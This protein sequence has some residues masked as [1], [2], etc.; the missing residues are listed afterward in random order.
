MSVIVNFLK[1]VGWKD[2]WLA[3]MST[4]EVLCLAV[5]AGMDNGNN[6]E[7]TLVEFE[8]QKVFNHILSKSQFGRKLEPVADYIPILV[9]QLA[10]SVEGVLGDKFP[11]KQ[12]EKNIY[13]ID[14]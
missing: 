12:I 14:L 1:I 8:N 13:K 10:I 11:L 7:K 4:S 5:V 3:K 2:H 9:E 6:H